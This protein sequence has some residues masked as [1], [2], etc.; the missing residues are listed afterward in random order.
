M[1]L[2]DLPV[3]LIHKVLL[4]A[5]ISRGVIRALR[6]RLVCKNFYNCLQPALFESRLLDEF[7]VQ[8]RHNDLRL[9]E[10]WYIRKHY[11]AEKLWQS[12]LAYRVRNE[13]DPGLG[14][15]VE[16]RRV[17]E[18]LCRQTEA[19]YE[20]TVNALCWLALERGT[21]YPG[22]QEGWK[23]G[24]RADEAS[25]PG[26]NLLSVAAYFDYI[27][28]AKRLLSD[29]HCPTADNDLF[30]SPMQLA[31]WAGNADM[32]RLFQE[33][34]PNFEEIPPRYYFDQ[35][36][37]RGKTGPDSIK[38]AALRGD[39]NMVRL[40]VYPPSRSTPDNTD[41]SGQPFGHVDPK[42]IPCSDLR[43]ALFFAKTWEV[44]QYIDSFFKESIISSERVSL[45]LA[46]YAELGDV[47]IVQQLLDAGAD[48]YGG[49]RHNRNPLVI[50]ARFCHEN[51]VDLLLE[52]GAD[53]N[54][55][56]RQQRGSPLGAAV[57]GGS[58]AIVK[59]L[60]DHGANVCEGEYYL[61]V[62]VVRLEHTAMLELLLDR[63]IDRGGWGLALKTA[64]EN[65]L[66]SMAQLLQQRGVQP[67][68]VA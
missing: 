10:L 30:P 52:R 55:L 13:T 26:L 68:V 28:L 32:L 39:M 37:W 44:F 45:L 66:E 36:A 18:D 27:A 31:A 42:S 11:G 41:F 47:E 34:L 33:H 60:F 64:L 19:E 9:M 6:L 61:F 24:N 50:A 29:G 59:K 63:V 23:I 51:V 65:G 58:M 3:D 22:F 2:L 40:A 35:K 48:I 38:G 15:F 1:E 20:A 62:N 43:D 12:Y 5:V 67:A 57:A 7:G 49:D 21:Y 54:N 14:R 17:A 16:I 46:R 4:Y 25:N 53:P 56:D 8:E